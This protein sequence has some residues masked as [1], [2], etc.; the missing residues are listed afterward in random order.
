MKTRTKRLVLPLLGALIAV[1][2]T[3]VIASAVELTV[4]PAGGANKYT[5]IAAA[6]NAAGP[7]DTIVCE[8][9]IYPVKG[10]TGITL[11]KSLTLLGAQ[12]GVDA[13]TRGPN[14]IPNAETVMPTSTS[15]FGLYAVDITIDGF[16]FQNMG[17]RGFDTYGNPD[18]LAIRNCIFKSTAGNYQGGNIQFG[19]S[20][21]LHAHHFIFERNYVQN[22]N[23]HMIYMGHAMDYGTI[24]NNYING[25]SF[26]F[27]PFGNR[28]GWVIEGNEF[29]GDV[30]GLGPYSGYGINANLGDVII[31]NNDVHKMFVG[32]GQISVVGGSI[33]NNV[34]YDNAYAA[35]QLWGGEWGSV[36]SANVLIK[37]NAISYNGMACT[38]YL[39]AAH[40]IRLR[41]DGIDASTI[42]INFNCFT[43][44]GVGDCGQAWAIRQL[45]S[46]AA[47]AELN[48]WGTTN[49]ATIATM[50]VQGTVDYDPWLTG[51]S[52]TGD[53]TFSSTVNLIL[54]AT[55]ATSADPQ[56]GIPVN[57]LVDGNPVGMQLTDSNGIAILDWGIQPAGTYAVEAN[58]ATGC[59]SSGTTYVNVVNNF[60]IT[61]SAGSNGEI[62]PSGS[63]TVS[64][65]GD[66]YFTVTP[67]LGYH[68]ADVKV[69]GLS[70]GAFPSYSFTNVIANHTIAASFALDT[71]ALTVTA[72]NG[73][74]AKA[75]NQAL[76]NH[77]TAVALTA[78]PAP[79]YHFVNWSGA[80]NGTANPINVVMDGPK[81][82]TANFAYYP[83]AKLIIA[84][85]KID[86]GKKPTDDR[87]MVKGG[88]TLPP[89]SDGLKPGDPVTI[90]VDGFS[91][92]ITM[93]VKDAGKKWE[94]NR[95]KGDTGIKTMKLDLG[96]SVMTFEMHVDK[97]DLAP[98]NTWT[99]P[100][101]I[102]LQIGDDKGATT[103]L[104]RQFK[105]SWE[106]H[107]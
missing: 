88:F 55:V 2:A 87:I 41:P 54:E 49:E 104:M 85:A 45:G 63:Q 6:V 40:G 44:L 91:Q 72:V 23:G 48:Y 99:N 97:L 21:I 51:I 37:N 10:N 57:F 66:L 82:V 67:D 9:G 96:K 26:A 100:V 50:F 27:G 18:N 47:D 86:W 68:I 24:R 77:G 43:N 79:G 5:T 64:A 73:T 34:F 94:Y 62:S 16:N 65:G 95:A 14:G 103:V 102:S 30:P 35:F 107:K 101:P 90:S 31:R 29:N 98:M 33:T 32:I 36:V 93:V 61:A 46:S 81:S 84:E 92:T 1:L 60:T 106:Y 22:L 38:G 70:V 4:N 20:E 25:D 69:D 59:L 53:T 52:Y 89:T 42:H 56:A 8:A 78:T 3:A 7:N 11:N 28:I 17:A 13:R 58:I 19:G 83:F 105:E 74:V 76:Y 80:V 75:P 15:I 71:Y 12:A 39:D